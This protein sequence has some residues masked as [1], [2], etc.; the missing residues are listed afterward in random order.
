MAKMDEEERHREKERH[1]EVEKRERLVQTFLIISGFLVAYTSEEARRFVLVIFSLY[2]MFTILYYV[3]LSRTRSSFATNCFAFASSAFYSSL[4]GAFYRSVTGGV[5]SR[6]LST[7]FI[8]LTGILT[9]ALLSP[10]S[11]E[12]LD[13]WFEKSSKEL[14]EKH[15]RL[16]K[17]VVVAIVVIAFFWVFYPTV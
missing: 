14:E 13:N 2:L 7:L 1:R 3:Y 16:Q 6:N 12:R 5:S 10:E 9:Y 17:I 8:L 15:P 11:S 4:M